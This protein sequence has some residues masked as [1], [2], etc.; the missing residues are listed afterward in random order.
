[1]YRRGKYAPAD[2]KKGFTF[3]PASIIIKSTAAVESGP[4]IMMESGFRMDAAWRK[5]F[6]EKNA[7]CREKRQE[8]FERGTADESCISYVRL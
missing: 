3:K 5:S 4:G 6:D 7:S 1:M 8:S 2:G